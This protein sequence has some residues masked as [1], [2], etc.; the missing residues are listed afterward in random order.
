MDKR[1]KTKKGINPKSDFYV[2]ENAHK[3][4][5]DLGDGTEDIVSD[6]LG[7]TRVYKNLDT[8]KIVAEIYHKTNCT[9]AHFEGT[10]TQVGKGQLFNFLTG[11]GV[12]VNETYISPL[13]RYLTNLINDFITN[14]KLDYIHDKLGWAKEND[15]TSGYLASKSIGAAYNSTLRKND[16]HLIGPN[17]DKEIYDKMIENEV[18]PNKSLHLPLVLGFIAPLVPIMSEYTACPVLITN[19]AG[20]SSQGKTT[21]M[22]LMASIWGN[23]KIS[24]TRLAITKSF[25]STQNGIEAGIRQNNGFP[26]LYDDYETAGRSINFGQLIYTLAQGESK[27][28]CGKDGRLNDTFNWRTHIGF[29]GES[30]IFNKAG[31]NL[32]LK[33]RIVEFKN[34]QWTVSKQNSINITSVVTKHY[35][36]YGEKF[37][38]ELMKISKKKLVECYDD[39]EKVI[40][41]MLP[42]GDNISERIQTRLALIRMTSILVRD[43]MEL[44]IDVDYV[45]ELLVEN[46]KERQN[47][48]DIYQEAMEKV[49][50]FLNMNYTSFIT[51]DNITKLRTIPNKQIYG[52][53]YKGRQGFLI[54]MLPTVLESIMYEFNDKEA[55]LEKWRDEG[56]LVCDGNRY[57]KVARIN[58]KMKETR[59]YCFSFE[60]LTEL[61]DDVIKEEVI[62]LVELETEDTLNSGG[63]KSKVRFIDGERY[64]HAPISNNMV[65][66]RT[67]KKSSSLERLNI[68]EPIKPLETLKET[69]I[70]EINYDD[71]ND[72]EEIFKDYYQEQRGGKNNED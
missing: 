34:K 40:N 15:Y 72:I 16:E 38:Q 32:G 21:S 61:Y 58:E 44:D 55:I 6:E 29:T 26:V 13:S 9:S 31:H 12:V 8:Q 18:V 30:S 50:E 59:C 27:T 70:C 64:V 43:L 3:I 39:C 25:A 71:M 28:R 67:I 14:S 22:A 35:G 53:I 66:D 68:N 56:L 46:E 41:E 52:R 45:T 20:K 48:P 65:L 69:P 4:V 47:G 54:A 57:T 49:I 63:T 11:K 24:N 51:F 17:G 36:F 42:S 5:F 37:V 19:F 10:L 60:K 1:K 2:D 23:G 33:P 7:V 62:E